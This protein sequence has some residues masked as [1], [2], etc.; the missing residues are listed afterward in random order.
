MGKTT[1]ESKY[2]REK[3][4]EVKSDRRGLCPEKNKGVVIFD[5]GS[6]KGMRFQGAI[7]SLSF[8]LSLSSCKRVDL[9]D[10]EGPY[11]LTRVSPVLTISVQK[12]CE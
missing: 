9:D 4:A 7:L 12:R 1:G 10:H 6:L 2:E 8:S 5:V 11:M 3:K